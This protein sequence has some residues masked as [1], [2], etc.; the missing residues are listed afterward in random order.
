[1]QT[2]RPHPITHE[3]LAFDEANHFRLLRGGQIVAQ[4]LAHVDEI[5]A[6]L[7]Q[8]RRWK[9]LVAQF[10][11]DD[12]SSWSADMPHKASQAFHLRGQT[13]SFLKN[14]PQAE[15]DLKA[16]LELAPR[17][18]ALWLSLADNYTHNLQN[19]GQALAA[20]RQ[21]FAITGKSNGW[22]PLTATV[23]IARLLTD[24]VKTAEALAVLQ[25]YGDM[26]GMAPSWRIRMLRAYGH[27][28][29][30][31]GKSRSCSP[32]SARRWRWNHGCRAAGPQPSAVGRGVA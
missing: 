15:S 10:A 18:A 30:R 25:Q 4:G 26:E 5:H 17:N 14:G 9:E 21:A 27:V 1:M 2:H 31:K 7:Q 6:V 20:Y 32:S 22:Q 3:Q 23:A 12:F 8:D 13:H 11:A 29:A 24:Q 19:D 28:C 16:A